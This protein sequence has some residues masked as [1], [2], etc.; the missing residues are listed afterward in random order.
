MSKSYK[1]LMI[2]INETVTT[3]DDITNAYIPLLSHYVGVKELYIKEWI[4]KNNIDVEQ[5]HEDVIRN[6]T[7]WSAVSDRILDVI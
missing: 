1:E 4:V 6:V 5:L 7:S 3:G 2:V